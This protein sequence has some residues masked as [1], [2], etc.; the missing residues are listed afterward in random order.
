MQQRNKITNINYT[1]GGRTQCL[2]AWAEGFGVKYL[3]LYHHVHVTKRLTLEEVAVLVLV[4]Q[5]FTKE[6][7]K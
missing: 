2:S 1:L 5:A 4:A 3:W 7:S 6:S